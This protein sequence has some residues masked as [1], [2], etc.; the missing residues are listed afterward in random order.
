M[1]SRVKSRL[2]KGC[3]VA[4]SPFCE[5]IIAMR[6]QG[7][8]FRSIEKFLISEGEEYRISAPTIHRNLARTKLAVELPYAEEV[9]ER[10]GGRIDL[11][12]VREMS[13]QIMAQ[14]QRI[15]RLQRAEVER[16]AKT[17]GYHD[18]RI[19][20]ERDSLSEMIKTLHGMMKSPLDAA[21][22]GMEADAILDKGRTIAL[23]PDAAA[24]LKDMI[25]SGELSLTDTS[26]QTEH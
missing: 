13:G 25:L 8:D 4:R 12:L 19:R 10:W 16:Q 21:R 5:I 22:E 20:Q 6:M 23:T 3:A 14:R 18:K 7:V 26:Q 15:D 17:P 11:D 24:V 2:P 9:A 1:I